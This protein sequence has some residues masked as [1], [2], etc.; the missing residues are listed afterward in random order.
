MTKLLVILS[1]FS[2]SLLLIAIMVANRPS[3]FARTYDVCTKAHN[4]ISSKSER[5]CADLLEENNL[6]FT[7][8]EYDV[9]SLRSK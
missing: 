6:I 3:A 4:E 7:C 2:L 1:G 8:N 5:Q 9:C